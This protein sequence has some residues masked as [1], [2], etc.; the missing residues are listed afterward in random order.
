MQTRPKAK[1]KHFTTN[2]KELSTLNLWESLNLTTKLLHK[3]NLKNT[4]PITGCGQL[5][6]NKDF[7]KSSKNS[8]L[9]YKAKTTIT[10]HASYFKCK[11]GISCKLQGRAL[12][13]THDKFSQG[14]IYLKPSKF[15]SR[16]SV[17]PCDPCNLLIWTTQTQEAVQRI[18]FSDVSKLLSQKS[19]L[20]KNS[21]TI[22][23]T[24][25]Q[26]TKSNMLFGAYVIQRTN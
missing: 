5:K 18:L 15:M 26:P 6:Q 1:Q 21:S 3:S 17:F 20:Q 19:K 4:L 10:D 14:L 23:V 8:A 9:D 7:L 22:L 11:T 25:V 16:K 13:D 2:G 24:T 12:L